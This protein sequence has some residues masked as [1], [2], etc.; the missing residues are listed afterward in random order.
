MATGPHAVHALCRQVLA[1]RMAT[2][3]L[4]A[5]AALARTAPGPA[6]W[7][8]AAAVLLTCALSYA[9]CHGWER[10]GPWLLRHRRTLAADLAIGAPL[11]VTAPPGSPLGLV[12]LGTPLLAGLAHGRRGAAAYA[13]AQAGLV[14]L[15]GLVPVAGGRPATAGPDVPGTLVLPGLCLLAGAAGAQLRD[16]LLRLDAAGRAL[17]RHRSGQA[18]AEATSAERA[19]LARELHDSLGKTLHGLALSAEALSRTPDPATAGTRAA[20]IAEAARRAATESRALL[21]DLRHDGGT[22]LAHALHAQ[23]T[24]FARE[25]GLPVELTTPAPDRTPPPRLPAATAAEVLAMTAEALEN[26]RRHAGARRIRMELGLEGRGAAG[27]LTL[28]VTDDGRGGLPAGT[29]PADLARAGHFGLLG[30]T[31]RAEAVGARLS[32][33]PAP[34]GAGTE[35]RLSLPFPDGAPAPAPAAARDPYPDRRS[36]A[37]RCAS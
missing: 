16:L 21:T 30:M 12:L 37:C 22:D 24:A 1:L 32:F 5:P 31:E 20:G 28:R 27:R 14:L 36:P 17:A 2:T 13:A 34:H 19:R 35:V 8:L 18:A 6:T 26:T 15:A 9:L 23:A 10:G 11:L 4:T 29:C 25:T 33:G 7:R 3:A